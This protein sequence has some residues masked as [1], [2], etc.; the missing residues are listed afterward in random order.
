MYTNLIGKC[1]GG[2]L[3]YREF[4]VIS[5]RAGHLLFSSQIEELVIE[6]AHRQDELLT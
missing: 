4:S 6:T 5:E 3:P 2:A 1:C